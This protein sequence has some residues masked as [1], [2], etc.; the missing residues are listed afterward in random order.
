MRI[1][2]SMQVH[3]I[4]NSHLDP[5]WLWDREEGLN[6]GIKTCRTMVA[7]LEEYPE[8]KIHVLD[9]QSASAGELRQALLLRQLIDMLDRV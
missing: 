9:S 5:V 3:L 2:R 6:E 1:P 4:L 8:K 7:L